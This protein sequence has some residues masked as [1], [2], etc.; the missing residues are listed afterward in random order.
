MRGTPGEAD[1]AWQGGSVALVELGRRFTAV[2]L[3]ADIVHAAAG[4]DEHTGVSDALAEALDGGPV[5]CDP[6]GRRYYALTPVRTLTSWRQSR[7]AA[8]L[9]HATWLGIPRPSDV[10]PTG[11]R[12]SYWIVPV[13]SVGRVCDPARVAA[14]V[15]RGHE[16]L[17]Q[18]HLDH[19]SQCPDCNDLSTRCRIGERMRHAVREAQS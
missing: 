15:A 3:S 10:A 13:S 4:S 6:W 7:G 19:T 11:A 16:H 1:A 12:F 2:R 18:A 5:I 9:G 17:Y 14:V 8:C